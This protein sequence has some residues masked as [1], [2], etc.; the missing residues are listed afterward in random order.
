MGSTTETTTK[1]NLVFSTTGA[2]VHDDIADCWFMIIGRWLWGKGD[3]R[4]EVKSRGPIVAEWT[5]CNVMPIDH[6]SAKWW[7][8]CYNRHVMQPRS[9]NQTSVWR[10]SDSKLWVCCQP[11][12]LHWSQMRCW[13]LVLERLHLEQK[14]K[15]MAAGHKDQ[16]N[17]CQD[18]SRNRRCRTQSLQSLQIVQKQLC[19]QIDVCSQHELLFRSSLSGLCPMTLL[20]MMTHH[21]YIR[22]NQHAETWLVHGPPIYHNWLE[23][24][25]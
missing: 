15:F 22:L 4:L 11:S 1:M 3:T 24:P 19:D 21:G 9:G 16:K 2:N 25:V 8:L 23:W 12:V 14:H 5:W 10:P 17:L 7:P 6:M 20:V 13:R 18:W